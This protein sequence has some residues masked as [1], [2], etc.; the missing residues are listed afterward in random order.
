MINLRELRFDNYLQ[1]REGRLCRVEEITKSGFKAPSI[2][3]PLT[4][5]PHSGVPLTEEWLVKMGFEKETNESLDWTYKL[6]YK[7]M[8]NVHYEMDSIGVFKNGGGGWSVLFNCSQDSQSFL[9]SIKY[10][11]QLQNLCHSLTGNE[12]KI[13]I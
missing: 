10:V 3:G 7:G 12:L 11:H 8:A 5:L 13:K 1:D 9:T 6:E 2:S 4:S